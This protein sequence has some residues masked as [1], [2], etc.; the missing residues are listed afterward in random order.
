MLKNIQ[1]QKKHR[2]DSSAIHR[3]GYFRLTWS[4]FCLWIVNTL[5]WMDLEK[6]EEIGE[7]NNEILFHISNKKKS[8]LQWTNS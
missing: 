4:D 5:S 7:Q 1:K 8:L 3:I 2:I 6:I